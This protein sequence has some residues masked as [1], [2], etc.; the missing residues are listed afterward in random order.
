M[1]DSFCPIPKSLPAHLSYHQFFVNEGPRALIAKSK[2]QPISRA[3]GDT[4]KGPINILA[5]CLG[6]DGRSVLEA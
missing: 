6:T 3:G 5:S 2:K 4:F 1:L